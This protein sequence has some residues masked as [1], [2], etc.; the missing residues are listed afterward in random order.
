MKPMDESQN[1]H[2]VFTVIANQKDLMSV[3]PPDGHRRVKM[4][5]LVNGRTPLTCAAEMGHTG[6]IQ[7]LLQYN[8]DINERDEDGGMTALHRTME[9]PCQ[10]ETIKLLLQSG[11][12]V[13]V[14]DA[15]GR[16][17]LFLAA[18]EGQA[19]A[20]DLLLKYNANVNANEK[21]SYPLL[22][23]ARKGHVDLMELLLNHGADIDAQ[24]QTGITAL[25]DA[26]IQG[27]VPMTQLLLAHHAKVNVSGPHQS[28]P[29]DLILQSIA[30]SGRSPDRRRIMELLLEH[31]ADMHE[32]RGPH[33]LSTLGQAVWLGDMEILN[34]L[35]DHAGDGDH[36]Q[37]A[38]LQPLLCFAA[39]Q[40]K[41]DAVQL[42]T[43][44]GVSIF[45]TDARFGRNA[46][47]WAASR[48]NQ[49]IFDLLLQTPEMGWNKADR[50]GRTPLF[51]A[52]L[53]G[54][55][56]FFKQLT[57]LGSDVHRPDRF[58]LTPLMIAVQHGHGD[59]IRQILRHD[60]L[61]QE[62]RDCFGRNLSW[63][64]EVTGNTWVR[65]LL[66]EYG[67]QLGDAQVREDERYPKPEPGNPGQSCD[68]CT[69]P[70]YR[71]NP[72]REY[73]SGCEK[74]RICPVCDR[75]GAQGADFTERQPG[76]T[77]QGI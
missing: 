40:R 71:E 46:I 35:L 50:I 41:E 12:D 26:V 54:N 66:L 20:V 4:L 38:I 19:V 60:P 34:L 32:R 52:A 49:V 56:G 31:G 42:L 76:W 27:N 23:A 77:L 65:E 51:Y 53:A 62:P 9:D 74:Y 36:E 7:L 16:T 25:I 13:E 5:S 8:E 55:E 14:A 2:E 64:M 47:S 24:G 3:L 43:K 28:T 33:Q 48:G 63:W 57:L 75:L 18:L 15:H 39:F 11:A 29:L 10:E 68:V 1:I 37:G 6:V 67:M 44:R 21:R 70:L 73:G 30:L 17:P 59:I 45:G 58:G 61:P 69:L 22:A 72:G